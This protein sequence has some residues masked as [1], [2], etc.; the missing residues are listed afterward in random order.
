MIIIF[1][2][3]TFYRFLSG[4][5]G[6]EIN[7]NVCNFAE[8]RL[9]EVQSDWSHNK[10]LKRENDIRQPGSWYENLGKNSNKPV[11]IFNLWKKS[12]KHNKVLLSDMKYICIKESNGYWVLEGWKPL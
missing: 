4:V 10:F 9:V 11:I 5:P 8:Q 12:P 3:L 6:V 1:A 2:L 7:Q